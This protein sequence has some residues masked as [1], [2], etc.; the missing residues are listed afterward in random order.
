MA[1]QMRMN[2]LGRSRRGGDPMIV[3]EA[4]YL[5]GW[6][7]EKPAEAVGPVA[8]RRGSESN[9]PEPGGP[10]HSGFE[11]RVTNFGIAGRTCA[12]TA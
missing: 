9:T 7:H 12:T 11:D 8:W 6:F 4:V 5:L 1:W 3:A 2:R 10:A